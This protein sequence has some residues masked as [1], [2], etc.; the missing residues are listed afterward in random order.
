VKYDVVQQSLEEFVQI[1]W[2]YTA[3]QYDNIAFNSDIYHEYVRSSVIFGEGSSRS[4]TK[5]C[6]RQ[7]GLLIITVFTKPAIGTARKLELANLAAEMMRHFV[8]LPISPLIAPAV[9]LKVPDLFNDP[10]EQSGWVQAQ[11]SCPFYYDLES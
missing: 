4:V 7:A 11:V 9:N 6:Y 8:V 3:V 5:G 10:K 2:T 1:N